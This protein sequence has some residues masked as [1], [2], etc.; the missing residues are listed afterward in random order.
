MMGDNHTS[1]P[2]RIVDAGQ[3]EDK[4]HETVAGFDVAK[5]LVHPGDVSDEGYVKRLVEDTI[6][7]FGKLDLFVN[8]AAIVIFGPFAQTT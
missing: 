1:R 6:T 2:E 4:L 7:Q 8:N 5:S 3:R